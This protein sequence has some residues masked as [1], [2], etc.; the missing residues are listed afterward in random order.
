MKKIATAFLA[1][2]LILGLALTAGCVEGGEAAHL[3]IGFQPSI[4]HAA[5]YLA[6]EKGWW[7]EDLAP[8]GITDVSDKRFETG[9][10][11]MQAMLA[12]EID[13]AYSGAA[14]VIAAISSGLDAKIVAAAQTQG[15]DLVIRSDIPYSSPADLKGLT[16]GT[17]PPGSIQ[18]T[19]LRNW[20]KENDID[21]DRDLEIKAMGP[22]DATTAMAAGQIDGAFLPHPH[23][24]IIAAQGHGRSVVQ[25]GEMYPNHVCCVVVASGRLIREQPE[26]VEQ[27]VRTHIRA[28]EYAIANPDEAAEIFV[29]AT[30]MDIDQVRRSLNEWDGAWVSDPN[31]I[32]EPVEDYVRIQHELGYIDQPLTQDDI[33]D[34]SFYE[35]VRA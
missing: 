7:S 8:H 24:S 34:L 28:T 2:A 19:I 4:D 12:G 35:K 15:S 26:V 32:I 30:G 16:I 22:G 29:G 21:P 10:P 9:P 13:V 33:F 3:R 27:I 18:D 31:L 25:S 6:M 20:L 1:A 5:H 17:Y 23:P 14:P 11:E